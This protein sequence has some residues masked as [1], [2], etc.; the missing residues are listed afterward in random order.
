MMRARHVWWIAA[1][2]VLVTTR[3][4]AQAVYES[5]PKT[6]VAT[7]AVIEK[8]SR[9]VTLKTSA[10]NWLHVTAPDEMEGFNRLKVG[11]VVTATYFEAIAV[12][13]RKPDDPLPPANPTTIVKRRDDTPGSRT[14]K[15][16]SIRATVKTVDQAASSLTVTT[17]AGEERSLTVTDP[18][19]LKPIKAGDTIDV[20]Y[21]ESLLVSVARPAKH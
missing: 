14:M 21:Y 19:Q 10:G 16:Q 20:T 13:L 8:D 11:D 9:V 7:I 1:L 12:R 6:L 5:T 3:V 17:A 18:A 4:A 15:E 2:A